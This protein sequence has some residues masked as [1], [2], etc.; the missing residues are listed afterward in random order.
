MSSRRSAPALTRG[1]GFLALWSLV[2]LAF[3]SQFY[4]SSTILGH[5]V[6]WSEALG[7]SLA[8]WYVWAILSLPI[9]WFARRFPPDRE[10]RWGTALLHLAAACLCSG[11]YIVLRTLIGEASARVAGES[12]SFGEIFQPLLART[13]P[14]NLLVYGVI[15]AC[16]QALSYYRRYHAR[17]VQALELE[18]HLAQARLQTLLHQLQP[19][20]LFNSLNG[21][22]S[23][24]YRDVEAADR[25][26]VRLGELLRV[27]ISQTGAQQSSLR[28]EISFAA[29]YLEIEQIRFGG[30]LEVRFAVEPEALGVAV[31]S[32]LLQPLVENAV[33]HGIEPH[34]RPGRVEITARRDAE[35][36]DITVTDNGDGLKAEAPGAGIGLGNT[37]ARLHQLYGPRHSFVIGNVPA[38]GCQVRLR[39]P[40]EQAS[41]EP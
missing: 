13:F 7:A 16:S 20:F 30:R 34:A 26:L 36:L 6:T 19:H 27:S 18:K 21:I 29:G 5:S 17:T 39:L 14:F 2:G 41:A 12:T 35:W 3:A 31:P 4:L 32:F 33:R 37:R 9:L 28:D 10:P 25:M 11:A 23:L 8:D 22:A 40:I 24:M 1:A 38:G 15:V